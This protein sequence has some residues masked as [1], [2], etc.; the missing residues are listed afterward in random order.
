MSLRILTAVAAAAVIGLVS[1][2]ASAKTKA[3]C[4]KEWQSQKVAMQA[5]GKTEKSYVADCRAASATPT[6][7]P[8]KPQ[9]DKSTY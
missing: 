8:A 2:P 6:S 7:A 4:T 5:A 1:A 9:G 3:E